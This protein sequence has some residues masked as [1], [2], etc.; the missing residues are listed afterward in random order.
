[1]NFWTSKIETLTSKWLF[2]ACGGFYGAQVSLN[3]VLEYMYKLLGYLSFHQC[4]NLTPQPNTAVRFEFVDCESRLTRI[5]SFAT[6]TVA[7]SK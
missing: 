6:M 7:G 3:S 2:A 5:E 4:N 1:L